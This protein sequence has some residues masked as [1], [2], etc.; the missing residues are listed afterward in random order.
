MLYTQERSER[1]KE[2]S[3]ARLILST[4]VMGMKTLLF[5]LGNY[6]NT[7]LPRPGVAAPLVGD[8]LSLLRHIL[9]TS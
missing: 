3:D 4:L 2:V 7:Q 5:S 8:P 1:D 9:V 6:G